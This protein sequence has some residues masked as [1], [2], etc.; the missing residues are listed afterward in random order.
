MTFSQFINQC[1][2]H[3]ISLC[4]SNPF[5]SLVRWKYYRKKLII[6]SGKFSSLTGFFIS[7]PDKVFIGNNVTINRFTLIDASEGGKIFI[8]DNCLIGPYVLIRSADH[9]F[10]D[11]DLP[12]RSQG[13][14]KGD[15][16][17]E[18][19]C[20][21]G[22]HVTITR[23]V[24]I[25]KGSIVGANSVVTKNIPPFSIAAG[26]PAKIIKDRRDLNGLLK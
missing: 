20:W 15:I 18:D 5:F 2:E 23:N 9:S 25:G 3:F 10:I 6:G 19:N 14:I 17:I 21:I 11:T 24:T 7:A 12:I 8:G 26:S 16:I 13:H 1:I 4:P 22:G